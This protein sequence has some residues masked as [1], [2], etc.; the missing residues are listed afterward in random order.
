MILD[1]LIY[2]GVPFA[3]AVVAAVM[4]R[5]GLLVKEGPLA[6]E[7]AQMQKVETCKTGERERERE[8]P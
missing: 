8:E 6:R 7:R 5:E 2:T 1:T 4:A 3:G